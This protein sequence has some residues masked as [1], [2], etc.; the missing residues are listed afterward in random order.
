MY[1]DANYP[2]TLIAKTL[3]VSYVTANKWLN[4]AGIKSRRINFEEVD[5]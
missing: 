3:G 4:M 2:V 1:V 5:K